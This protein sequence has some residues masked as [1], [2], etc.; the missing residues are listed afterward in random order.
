MLFLKT[1]IIVADRLT[2]WVLLH[3]LWCRP[4]TKCFTEECSKCYQNIL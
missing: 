2:K 3:V 4:C 1:F